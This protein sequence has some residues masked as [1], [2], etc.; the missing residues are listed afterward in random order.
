MSEVGNN[1]APVAAAASTDAPKP[2]V[3][4]KLEFVDDFYAMKDSLAN[5]EARL[6]IAEKSVA[7]IPDLA[8]RVES[9][10]N[11]AVEK[12]DVTAFNSTVE[13]LNEAVAG[14][15]AKIAAI[16]A[17]PKGDTGE[18]GP[19][20]PF[21]GDATSLLMAAKGLRDYISP[22]IDGSGELANFSR[23]FKPFVDALIAHMPV[24]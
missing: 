16:P 17:G 7:T 19:A 21:G 5:F 14:L 22:N 1:N 9:M 6:V 8:A 15:N 18:P 10:S 24:S 2:A 13:G 11:I 23:A 12:I 3:A 4:V 20:A